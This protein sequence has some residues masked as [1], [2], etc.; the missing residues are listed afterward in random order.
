[1]EKTKKP[2][3]LKNIGWLLRLVWQHDWFLLA[4]IVVEALCSV[5]IPFLGIYALCPAFLNANRLRTGI[6]QAHH[7][8]VW[9]C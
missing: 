3:M 9:G 6:T 7:I 4:I 5:A 8:A 2:P 1:M